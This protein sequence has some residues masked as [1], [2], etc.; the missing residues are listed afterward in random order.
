MAM[1]GKKVLLV[2]ADMRKPRQHSIFK[3]KNSAGL[4]NVL[5]DQN[6]ISRVLK[7]TPVPN[8]LLLTAGPPPPNPSELLGSKRMAKLATLLR[9]R[10][11]TVVFDTPPLIT[12]TDAAI[13]ATRL[14]GVVFVVKAGATRKEIL[15]RSKQKL[16]ELQANILGVIL[17]WMDMRKSSYY[18]YYSHYY[19]AYY[20]K[21]KDESSGT[22]NG[23]KKARGPKAVARKGVKRPSAGR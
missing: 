6:D 10:Y 19:S 16:E 22:D 13:L 15:R 17:N 4:S 21:E 11:D 14:D 3:V 9:E 20:G 1:A 18:Y 23:R 7:K 8:L 5:T 2:D 12:V